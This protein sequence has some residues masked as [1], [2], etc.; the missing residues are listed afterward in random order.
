MTASV[1]FRQINLSVGNLKTY[2]F[3]ILFVVGNLILPQVCHLVPDGGKIFLPIYFF[4]LIAAYKF[5][6]KVGLLTAI[7]SP[8]LNSLFFG[9]PMVAMLPVILIKSSLF[10]VAA[11]LIASK[12]KSVS[13]P[14][15]ALTILAYQLLGGLA[16]W[17]IAGQFSAALQ[18]FR[19]GFPG[20]LVQWIA[21]WGLLRWMAKYEL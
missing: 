15:I 5:G 11:S 16:E 18:D 13:L 10:A 14:L 2:L 12:S 4:T 19:I 8:L 1:P 7:F 6:L 21:G 17:A 20:M 3:S 9:M